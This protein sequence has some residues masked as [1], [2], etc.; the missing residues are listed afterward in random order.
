MLFYDLADFEAAWI[1]CFMRTER[2]EFADGRVFGPDMVIGGKGKGKKTEA[3]GIYPFFV[4]SIQPGKKTCKSQMMKMGCGVQLAA[5]CG[6]MERNRE[7]HGAS[8]EWFH[9]A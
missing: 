4:D 5:A 6:P 8:A 3:V 1:W 2:G 9:N 7:G